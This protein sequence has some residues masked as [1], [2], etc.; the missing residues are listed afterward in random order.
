M[1]VLF[2]TLIEVERIFRLGRVRIFL[3]LLEQLVELS[4]QNLLMALVIIEGL[5]EHLAPSGFFAPELLNARAYVFERARLL[6]LFVA[7]DRLEF[8]I[9]LKRGL[10][11]RAAEFDQLILAFRHNLDISAMRRAWSGLL[12]GYDARAVVQAFDAYDLLFRFGRNWVDPNHGLR[13]R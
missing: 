6:R 1:E 7:D 4:L 13:S 2:K 9:D 5:L 3:G 10:A 8:R 12:I 11:A